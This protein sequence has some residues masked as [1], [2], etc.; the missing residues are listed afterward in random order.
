[1]KILTYTDYQRAG[2]TKGLTF[3]ESNTPRHYEQ[4]CRWT[5]DY[6]GEEVVKSYRIVNSK[7]IGCRCQSTKTLNLDSYY[8]LAYRLGIEFIPE[9]GNLPHNTK[10]MVKWRNPYTGVTVE[11]SFNELYRI[12]RIPKRLRDPLGV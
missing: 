5:C 7:E 12:N 1:M 6:C 10:S 11:A 9:E 3:R 8:E 2:K 4:K